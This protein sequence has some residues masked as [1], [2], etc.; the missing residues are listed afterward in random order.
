VPR[1]SLVWIS[2]PPC[3]SHLRMSERLVV[4]FPFSLLCWPSRHTENDR[5]WAELV[6]LTCQ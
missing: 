1:S 6:L 3:K 5:R 4:K 2:K